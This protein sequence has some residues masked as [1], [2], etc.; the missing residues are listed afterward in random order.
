MDRSV[1]EPVVGW[2]ASIHI[3]WEHSALKLHLQYKFNNLFQAM[4]E[5]NNIDINNK[6]AQKK[7]SR[8]KSNL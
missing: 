2:A 7:R 5:S 1:E 6:K 8:I 4:I 3:V